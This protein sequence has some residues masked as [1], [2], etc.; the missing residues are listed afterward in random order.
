MASS[1][2]RRNS[3]EDRDG[4]AQF[5]GRRLSRPL[6]RRREKSAQAT[7]PRREGRADN[8]SAEPEAFH[9]YRPPSHR[10]HRQPDEPTR[11]CSAA[12]ISALI[13]CPSKCPNFLDIGRMPRLQQRSISTP[14]IELKRCPKRPR[15]I[16]VAPR[17]MFTCA[18]ARFRRAVS[19]RR[20]LRLLMSFSSQTDPSHQICDIPLVLLTS[21]GRPTPIDPTRSVYLLL[22]TREGPVT[23]RPSLFY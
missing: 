18:A 11:P 17:H 20:I 7:R 19:K 13:P 12:N 1:S 23:I 6:S 9:F 5:R 21:R 16:Y 8:R 14:S 10:R 4:F 22:L 3:V 15:C 2:V